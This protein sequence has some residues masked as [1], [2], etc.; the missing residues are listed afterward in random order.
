[1]IYDIGAFVRWDGEAVAKERIA[2]LRNETKKA[3]FPNVHLQ[4]LCFSFRPQ[5]PDCCQVNLGADSMSIYNWLYKTSSRLNSKTEP[6]LTYRQWGEMSMKAADAAKAAA[7]KIGAVYFPNL[8]V[9]WDTNARYPQ[10][11]RRNIVHNANPEDFEY[12][13]GQVKKWADANIPAEMPKLITVN[14]WNEWTEGTYLEPDDKFGY[15]YLNALWRVFG[16]KQ[17]R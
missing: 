12:F 14:S 4:V 6:E 2:Y 13:A 1:M 3:G 5:D 15:G 17:S 10:N 9:G 16:T 8:T 7:V 11:E